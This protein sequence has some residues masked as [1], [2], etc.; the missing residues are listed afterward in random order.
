MFG[1]KLRFA[2]GFRQKRNQCSQEDS[3]ADQKQGAGPSERSRGRRVADDPRRHEI[4]MTI[5]GPQASLFH[6][7][8]IAWIN[9]H[10]P[11]ASCSVLLAIRTVTRGERRFSHGWAGWRFCG[12]TVCWRFRPSSLVTLTRGL[13][14]VDESS[15]R[16]WKRNSPH[17]ARAG[18]QASREKRPVRG[19]P[20][21]FSFPLSA[22]GNSAQRTPSSALPMHSRSGGRA[23]NRSAFAPRPSGFF[24]ANHAK[25]RK[26]RE[27]GETDF[28]RN[29]GGYLRRT[30]PTETG[31]RGLLPWDEPLQSGS[32]E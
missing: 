7:P 23:Q 3:I 29:R 9:I 20:A 12:S 2:S 26:T 24:F 25:I 31:K 11:R 18:K 6:H 17:T 4:N 14:R 19:R 8:G 30:V 13:G 21:R 22:S 16:K 28:T 10:S 15:K 27:D 5:A 1:V 32:F